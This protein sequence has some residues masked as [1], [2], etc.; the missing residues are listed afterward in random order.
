MFYLSRNTLQNL[1][2]LKGMVKQHILHLKNLLQKIMGLKKSMAREM[3]AD[4]QILE[5]FGK[6]NLFD[7]TKKADIEKIRKD[8]TR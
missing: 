3:D 5:R 2:I 6:L 8:V 7:G 1:I 4:V